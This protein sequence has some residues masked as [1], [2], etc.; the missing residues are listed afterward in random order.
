VAINRSVYS[1]SLKRNIVF[2]KNESALLKKLKQGDL[3]ATQMSEEQKS[4]AKNLL[5]SRFVL[6]YG[7]ALRLE[8]PK[9]NDL[10]NPTLVLKSEM[11]MK[12]ALKNWL[13]P[14]QNFRPSDRALALEAKWYWHP[15]HFAGVR[16][17]QWFES[18]GH[19]PSQQLE[20]ILT[21]MTASTPELDPSPRIRNTFQLLDKSDFFIL[22]ASDARVLLSGWEPVFEGAAS[23]WINPKLKPWDQLLLLESLNGLTNSH[24]T[25]KFQRIDRTL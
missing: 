9:S 13:E 14:L 6:S 8:A 16:A 1:G 3:P 25:L 12:L 21:H 4:A 7:Q 22:S 24:T 17:W 2:T 23:E 19:S 5:P 11:K 15:Y 10:S 20:N 18:H